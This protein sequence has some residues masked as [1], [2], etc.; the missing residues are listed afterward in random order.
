VHLRCRDRVVP[1]DHVAVMGV[2][3]VTPDSFSDGGLWLDP[4]AAIKHALDMV[5]DG[6]SIIDVGGESTRPGA[7]PVSEA[8][9]LR[10]VIPVIEE[11]A[12]ESD[13]AISIDTRKPEVARRAVDAGA[14]II[15][16]T[17]G[18]IADPGMDHA[19]ADTGAAIV[20]MHSRGT[21]ET[22]RSLAQYE[23]VVKEVCSFLRRRGGELQQAGV[24]SDAIAIDPGFGFAKVPEHNLELLNRI[25]ELIDLGYPVVVGTSR[26]SF[27]GALLDLPESERL[28]GTAATVAWAVGR[29]AQIVRVHDVKEMF[30][31]V[32]VTEAIREVGRG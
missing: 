26:K 27:L 28:E 19:V 16:D 5:A 13:V 22:M 29:G 18:E 2:L 10:R 24:P 8:E 12:V 32:A 15:N 21:P 9:E 31:I 30:R 6:A 11:L 3:N 25:D 1:L 20:V 7:T 4:R 17:A 14:C 23:D